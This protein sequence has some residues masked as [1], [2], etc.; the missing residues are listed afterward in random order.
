MSTP[1]IDDLARAYYEAHHEHI[2]ATEQFD[3]LEVEL[4]QASKLTYDT[5][6]KENEARKALLAFIQSA[7][8]S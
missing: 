1:T 3:R 8:P 2:A 5:R 4:Q 6:V 7:P